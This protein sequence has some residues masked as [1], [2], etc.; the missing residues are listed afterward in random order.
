MIVIIT[1]VIDQWKVGSLSGTCYTL[2]GRQLELFA[3]I[4]LSSFIYF[5]SCE[6]AFVDNFTQVTDAKL[7]CCFKLLCNMFD[8]GLEK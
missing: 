2:R 7:S 1:S 8:A 3:G 4:F 5:R 6:E